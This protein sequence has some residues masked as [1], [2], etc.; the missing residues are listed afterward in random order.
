[1]K[2]SDSF[3]KLL[4]S[5]ST[6]DEYL[7]QMVGYLKQGKTGPNDTTANDK[8]GAIQAK[9][10][11]K[12]DKNAS[13]K[14]KHWN[15]SLEKMIRKS[16][17]QQRSA[18][19]VDSDSRSGVYTN[20]SDAYSMD[21]YSLDAYTSRSDASTF[22]GSDDHYQRY[23]VETINLDREEKDTVDQMIEETEREE[24]LERNQ[25]LE[26]IVTE[27]ESES[28]A[29]SDD[30]Q[31]RSTP[32]TKD[33]IE[34]VVNTYEG[35][36][37]KTLKGTMN[38]NH[39]EKSIEND[40]LAGNETIDN[41]V[42]NIMDA[43]SSDD[44]MTR[45]WT[46]FDPIARSVATQEKNDEEEVASESKATRKNKFVM[47]D[48][49]VGSI[50]DEI[51]LI[52]E[53]YT[54]Q[55]DDE[56]SEIQN[57]TE[58][59]YEASAERT[60]PGT[61]V[62]SLT[63]DADHY[64]RARSKLGGATPRQEDNVSTT[65]NPNYNPPVE[66]VEQ[67]PSEEWWMNN[68]QSPPRKSKKMGKEKEAPGTPSTIVIVN[69]S[70]SDSSSD[71]DENALDLE[72]KGED[73]TSFF[74]WMRVKCGIPKR[75]GNLFLCLILGSVVILIVSIILIIVAAAN[76]GN[77]DQSPT[78]LLDDPDGSLPSMNDV[79]V[80]PPTLAP[81]ETG[82]PTAA[83]IVLPT[84]SP[85]AT[86]I[87][88]PTPYPTG[89]PT[90]PPTGL[91]TVPP[92]KSPVAEPLPFDSNV[93]VDNLRDVLVSS[94]PESLQKW[95]DPLSPQARAVR[96]LISNAPNATVLNFSPVVEK[97]VLAVFYYS[98][99]GDEWDDNSGWLSSSD[100]CEWFST[101]TGGSICDSLGR[102]DELNLRSNN[103]KGPIPSELVLLKDQMIQIRLNG[104][105]LEGT[106]P[107]IIGEMTNLQ[108]FQIHW[109]SV[110]GTIPTSLRKLERMKSFKIGQNDM[111]G[112][113]P[114]E[115]GL[116]SNLETLDLGSNGFFGT[117]PSFLLDLTKL[118]T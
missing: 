113:I 10:D 64:A 92:T 105:S 69:R 27:F 118:G 82:S 39:D 81:I 37:K 44:G 107:S 29:P 58:P 77:S 26:Q 21:A 100:Q 95:E 38:N 111:V 79:L 4:W 32:S 51:E 78:A 115:L 61:M 91:P 84:R 90:K 72:G 30:H 52:V 99:N 14:K 17:V 31:E 70:F 89:D 75:H 112:T 66:D 104:N 18:E 47:D 12:V 114:S 67:G 96:W 103:L 46:D 55:L 25:I 13:V 60:D 7:K 34:S 87:K 50:S 11:R 42:T 110:S 15:S 97:Y 109:N 6:E 65:P 45:S 108:R 28:G 8:S 63:T 93:I 86:P 5:N 49:S 56:M 85:V 83:P 9:V 3:E 2:D 16:K 48:T 88:S 19:S 59:G 54:K 80:D 33:I 40:S 71:P 23:L 116:I 106:F 73:D 62:S 53:Q 68:H 24:E 20:R 102:I 36:K 98:T 35:S 94:L 117:F 1:M 43:A 101:S 22:S 76:I 57:T 41:I 74:E